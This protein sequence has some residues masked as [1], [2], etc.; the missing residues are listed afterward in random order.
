MQSSSISITFGKERGNGN[1][2]GDDDKIA[3][4]LELDSA[5]NG[6]KTSFVVN[7]NVYLKF[8]F[9][10]S[11]PYTVKSSMGTAGVAAMNIHYL[12]QDEEVQFANSKTGTLR[13]YPL[14]GVTHRWIGVSA[15]TPR[16]NGKEITLGGL[17]VAILNC[18]YKT[19]GDRLFI[20]SGKVGNVLVVAIQGKNQAS[21]TVNFGEKNG[22]GNGKPVPYELEVKDYCTDE[23]LSGVTIYL[24]D[25]DIGQ[26]DANGVIALGALVPGSTHSLRMAKGG[27]I[28]SEKD[29]LNNDSFTVPE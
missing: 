16:F 15:G 8:L 28:N 25:A 22:D 24:D 14:E 29:K 10:G 3:L 20:V 17:S 11:S 1:G 7:Q 6:G 4:S 13:Y 12:V 27:Y 18:T 19:K 26:T 9:P 23:I 2:N 21:L 5:A